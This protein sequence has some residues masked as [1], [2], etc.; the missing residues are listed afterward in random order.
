[1]FPHFNVGEIGYGPF[2]A[3]IAVLHVFV[4]HFAVGAG[5]FNAVTETVAA[6]RG[7]RL[8]LGFLKDNS[9]FIVLLP[10][11]LG[12][13]TGVGIWF[14]ISISAPRATG[15]L[16]HQFGW[17]WA[18]EWV[19]FAVEIAAGYAYFYSW[20]RVSPAEHRK[21]AWIYAVAAWMSLFWINGILTFMLSPG[22]WQQRMDARDWDGA[23]W[24]AFFNPSFWPSLALRTVSS[25]SLAAIFAAVVVNLRRNRER[26]ERQHIINWAGLWLVPLG[27]ML[28]LSL[29]YFSTVPAPAAKLVF[30]GSA[31]VMTMFFLFGVS[32][33]TLIGLY[34]Y[35]GLVRFKRYINLE[36]SLL[37]AALALM[38]T[39]TMEFVREGIRKPY[40][41]YGRMYANQID[42]SEVAG[43]QR[44]GYL[45]SANW[46]FSS[47]EAREAAGPVARGQALFA[48]QCRSC[49]TTRGVSNGI[50]PLIQG[51]SKKSLRDA[52]DELHQLRGRVMP[53][54]AGSA[55]E[56]DWLVE[57]LV[58]LNPTSHANASSKR[59]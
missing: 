45:P 43:Y 1:M 19:F 51:R 47:S 57:Y 27:L 40:V 26:D 23:F 16:I 8:L 22:D 37:L 18:I 36:T 28:P 25:L 9:K 4:A 38:A 35:F 13:V 12:A 53:P 56:M 7:D 55:E 17:A 24:T 3:A 48:G 49:H 21:L 11:V 14:A 39:G 6:R 10:F 34:A 50:A 58:Q 42:V 29:W 41:I 2:I 20:D 52:L 33:S 54:F 44:D 32:L 31:A 30:S 5:I 15:L 59:R 46:A